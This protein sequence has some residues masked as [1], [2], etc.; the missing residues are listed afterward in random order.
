MDGE[1][2]PAPVTIRLTRRL[3]GA[4]VGSGAM[5]VAEYRLVDG[6]V[7]AEYR[8]RGDEPAFWTELWEKTDFREFLSR[9]DRGHL[10]EFET[11]FKKYLPRKGLILEAGCGR[12]QYVWALQRLGYDVLGI[13]FSE[14]LVERAR[15]AEPELN[16][17]FGDVRRLALADRSVSAY[18]SLGVVEH[19]WEGMHGILGEARRV[20]T[21]DGLL[22]LS[23]PHFSPM[24][25]RWAKTAYEAAQSPELA[26]GAHF[27]QFYFSEQRIR[28]KVGENGFAV[29]DRWF[30]APLYGAKRAMPLFNKVFNGS[31]LARGVLSRAFKAPIPQ[32]L[33]ERF[34]H[35][36]L[37]V[38]TK[39]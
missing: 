18:V 39:R 10:G 27:Y 21:D 13:D 34:A 2:A 12:G 30:Y 3:S 29:M 38:A 36:I 26:G 7:L 20:L 25:R 23:V 14:P 1:L 31:Y 5:A 9:Y 22:L 32:R 11:V 6:E 16:I 4:K 19:F 24:W 35:M 8:S 28:Q 15:A 37:V 33:Q 17:R